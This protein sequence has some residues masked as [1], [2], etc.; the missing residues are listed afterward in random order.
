MTSK[1]VANDT[2]TPAGFL[3]EYDKLAAA[4]SRA[5]G[6]CET[7][8]AYSKSGYA[9]DGDYNIPRPTRRGDLLP[10][11]VPAEFLNESGLAWQAEQSAPLMERFRTG[12]RTAISYGITN[13]YLSEK[14]A[15]AA[16]AALGLGVRTVKTELRTPV[17]FDSYVYVVTPEPMTDD[18]RTSIK[19]ALG[20]A[21]DAGLTSA[22]FS[23]NG[24]PDMYV[25]YTDTITET[26]WE[27]SPA[28]EVTPADVPAEQTV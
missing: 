28:A 4:A 22:G 1:K 2:S 10:S 12:A 25:G 6:W 16:A 23:H 9:A 26:V 8:H 5:N 24:L 3:A 15:T 7:A 21:I 19:T 27:A 17:C 14:E 13:G 20:V 18:V 11:L